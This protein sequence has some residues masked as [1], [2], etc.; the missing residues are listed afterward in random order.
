MGSSG[1]AGLALT[2]SSAGAGCCEALWVPGGNVALG[3][4]PDEIEGSTLQESESVVSVSR[5]FLDR[6]EVCRTAMFRS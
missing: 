3:F 1:C 2:P 4:A 6:F 5:F